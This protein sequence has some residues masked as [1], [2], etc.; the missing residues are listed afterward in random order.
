MIVA[1]PF[2]VQAEL[3]YAGG[4]AWHVCY[5]FAEQTI[6]L[7]RSYAERLV[8]AEREKG[9]TV[10]YEIAQLCPRCEPGGKRRRRCKLCGGEGKLPYVEVVVN[11]DE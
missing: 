6:G 10:R 11:A 3:S 7:A 5:G 8:A 2:S 1:R 9:R 4:T